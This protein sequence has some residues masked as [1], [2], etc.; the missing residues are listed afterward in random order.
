M[1]PSRSV[2]RPRDLAPAMARA[3]KQIVRTLSLAEAAK[4]LSSNGKVLVF[5]NALQVE[6][7]GLRADGCTRAGALVVA[8]LRP[9]RLPDRLRL[10]LRSALKQ[11]DADGRVQSFCTHDFEVHSARREIEVVIDGETVRLRPPLRFRAVSDAVRLI[12]PPPG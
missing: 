10:L 9:T 1:A 2:A 5:R 11:L 4:Q 8:L 6:A 7:L 12:V 3:T